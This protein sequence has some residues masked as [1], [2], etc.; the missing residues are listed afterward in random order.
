M[1]HPAWRG[2][3]LRAAGLVVGTA[4]SL[5]FATDP[6]RASFAYAYSNDFIT[7]F[8]VAGAAVTVT[9][10][11]TTNQASFDGFGTSTPPSNPT[12]ARQAFV[13]PAPP[14]GQNSFSPYGTGNGQYARGDSLIS[15]T[16]QPI[17]AEN[18]AEAFRFTPGAA[19]A[20]AVD[21]INFTI[22]LK[23]NQ[24]ATF[25]F[26]AEPDM[27]VNTGGSAQA[28]AIILAGISLEDSDENLQLSWEPSG[29]TGIGDPAHLVVKSGGVSGVTDPFSLNKEIDCSG[30]CFKEYSNPGDD[31]YTL[32][33][34]ANSDATLN[35]LLFMTEEVGVQVPEPA[36]LALFTGALAAFGLTRR[37]RRATSGAALCL[38]AAMLWL[39]SA[40]RPAHASFAYSFSNDFITEFTVTGA[41][42][43]PTSTRTSNTATFDGFGTDTPP[44]NPTDAS[45]AFVGPAPPDG[46]NDF[47]RYGDVGQYAR[48]DSL[49]TSPTLPFTGENVAEA[50]R[51]TPGAASAVATT[52]FNFTIALKANQ[53]ATITFVAEPD[54]VVNTGG[55]AFAVASIIGSLELDAQNADA[56]QQLLWKPSGKTGVGD[57]TN[58][59]V[60]AGSVSGVTDPFS[61]NAT[62]VCGGDCFKEYDNPGSDTYSI[63]YKSNV[64]EILNGHLSLAELVTV[65]V[66]E[67]GSLAL[68]APAFLAFA[69]ARRMRR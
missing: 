55:S 25:S 7:E 65:Q 29:K 63:S 46:Q 39:G 45:E 53:P 20:V 49:I 56:D 31:T 11:S 21:A 1:A 5:A 24:P 27:V 58:L 17:T 38:L 2:R 6:A 50:F 30:D 16:R 4:A 15:S 47:G 3:G 33:Y 64:D 69:A 44:P 41:V 54:M 67:P 57:P 13:G 52:G 66:P 12:D 19:S 23:A 37:R 14:D 22:A 18:V 43:A 35:G 59:Q 42:V 26:T 32:T 48:A 28:V 61:L 10:S 34:T 60:D 51:S 9:G 8:S 36:S 40:A 62:I 68:L